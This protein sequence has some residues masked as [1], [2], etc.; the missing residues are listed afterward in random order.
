MVF[1][2]KDGNIHKIDLTNDNK[3]GAGRNAK[4]YRISDKECIKVMNKD[5]DNY[6]RQD[7]FD[8]FKSLSLPSFVKIDTPFYVDGK[9]KAYTMDYLESTD[10][11]ILDMPT[12]YTLDNLNR[13]YKDLLILSKYLITAFDLYHKNV[14]LGD[15]KMTVIDYDSYYKGD[16]QEEA[17]FASIWN[18][19]YTFRRLYETALEKKG[20]AVDSMMIG[21]ITISQYLAKYLFNY[22]YHNHREE[23]AKVLERKLVGTKTPMELFNRKW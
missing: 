18:L 19:M 10:K 7:I 9:I 22:D 11:S 23:P 20:I 1:F 3:I 14:I 6:F 8:I 15:D 16:T 13:I 21:N 5:P 4:V 2:D 17:L 12:E